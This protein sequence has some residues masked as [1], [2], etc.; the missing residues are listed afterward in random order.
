MDW[1][2]T[3]AEILTG[4][5]LRRGDLAIRDG[6]ISETAS[7]GAVRMDLPG[8]WLLPG[9]VDIHGDA[10]ERIVMPRPGVTFPLDL[11]LAEADRQMLANGITTAF[12]GLTV[13]WE[14]GLRNIA[15]ARAFVASLAG[16]RAKLACDT[17]INFR[18]E[19]FAIDQM[20]ELIAWFADSPGAIL[21][22]NDHTTVNV[23]LPPE[24]RKIRRMADRSGLTPEGCVAA[25]AHVA[26]RAPDVPASVARMVTAARAAGLTCLAHDEMSPED[27]AAHRA[28]GVAVSEFPMTRDTADAARAAGEAVV[29]GAPNVLRGGSQNNAVDAAPAMAEGLGTVLA[30]DYWYPAPLQA[31][32]VLADTHGMS[33]ANA[34]DCVSANA[35]AAAGLSDRGR[36]DAGLRADIVALCPRSRSVKAVWVAGKRML[37]RD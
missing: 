16:L 6:R 25:L 31:A 4:G 12:H 7:S 26:Q 30:S 15:T 29:F 3:G 20:D 32:F 8:L 33:F 1:V 14:P 13:G 5:A 18:W 2:L 11:S 9:I 17:R 21:S 28:L 37:I 24:A 23:G 35:A 27:R 19:V 34:W 36:L 22:L 10:I